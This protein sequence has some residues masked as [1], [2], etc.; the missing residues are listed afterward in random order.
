MLRCFICPLTQKQTLRR[1]CAVFFVLGLIYV[2]SRQSWLTDEAIEGKLAALR[3]ISL[4]R[5]LALGASG[6]NKS[7]VAE[8]KA[9]NASS[10]QVL[11]PPG[12]KLPLSNSSAH[13]K[14]EIALPH[15][16]E[17][18]VKVNSGKKAT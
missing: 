15:P 7:V 8:G 3:G 5:N 17:S 12:K 14:R 18:S 1:N 9:A 16:T 11:L 10:K 13:V 4:A 6:I 2:C